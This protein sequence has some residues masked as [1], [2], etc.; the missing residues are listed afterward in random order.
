MKIQVT[1]I[2]SQT[3]KKKKTHLRCIVCWPV[4][5]FCRCEVEVT[6]FPW[7]NDHYMRYVGSWRNSIK[8]DAELSS[9]HSEGFWVETVVTQL[10]TKSSTGTNI[11]YSVL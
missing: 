11:K 4:G 8:F 5:D 9:Y 1:E 3:S 10:N 6:G 2:Y 7:S